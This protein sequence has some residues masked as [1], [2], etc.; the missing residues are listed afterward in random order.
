MTVEAIL[1]PG[2]GLG[3]DGRLPLWVQRRFDRAL[4]A[5]PAGFY[6][7]LSAGTTFRPP[8][9][10]GQGFP[11]SEAAAGARYLMARG[12]PAERILIEACSWDTI[13]NAV[14]SRLLHV[15]PRGLRRLLVVTSAFHLARTE[16]AFRWVYGLEPPNGGYDL[17]FAPAPDDGLTAAALAARRAKEAAG[18]ARLQALAESGRIASLAALHAFLH[19]EHDAYSAS[20]LLRPRPGI[21]AEELESY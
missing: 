2:G 5:A 7:P 11:V 8:P 21:A 13:G 15:D 18:L 10:D 4:E 1:V 9:V 6:I 3:R 19:G 12:V 17:G 14:F 20:G 16:A